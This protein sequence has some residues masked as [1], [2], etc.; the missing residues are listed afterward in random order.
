MCNT[1]WS[2]FI[3]Y[4]PCLIPGISRFF[5][6]PFRELWFFLVEVGMKNWCPV[7]QFRPMGCQALLTDFV[8][9]CIYSCIHT[10][11]HTYVHVCIL[12]LILIYIKEHGFLL[13]PL[14]HYRVYSTLFLFMF[15]ISLTMRNPAPIIYNTRLIQKVQFEMDFR[16]FFGCQK[17][18]KSIDFFSYPF[19]NFL[20]TP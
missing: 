8:N 19:M 1:G 12:G 14:I 15:I 3:L 5:K 16:D 6:E 11:L 4:S 20:N 9:S 2:R 17:Y 7:H 10:Y 18:L 13:M